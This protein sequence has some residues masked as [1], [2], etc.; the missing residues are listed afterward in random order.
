MLMLRHA[1]LLLLKLYVPYATGHLCTLA[2]AAA[3]REIRAA[4]RRNVTRLEAGHFPG[5][6]AKFLR[7]H[8]Q[9]KFF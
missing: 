1:L 2:N 8:P 3:R 6:C 9:Q 5:L 4:K 7:V